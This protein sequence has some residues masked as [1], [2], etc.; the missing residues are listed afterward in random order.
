MCE[1]YMHTVYAHCKA[2]CP[3]CVFLC[4]HVMF[5]YAKTHQMEFWKNSPHFSINS[6]IFDACSNTVTNYKYQKVNVSPLCSLFSQK[7]NRNS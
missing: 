7:Y 1:L 4:I 6:I 2:M 5:M 3:L